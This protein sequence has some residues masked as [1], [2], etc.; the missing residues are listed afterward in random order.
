MHSATIATYNRIAPQYTKSHFEPEFWLKEFKIFRRL[1]RGKKVIDVGC[2]A[3]RDA[4]LFVKNKFNYTGVDA[5][6]GMLKIAKNRVR[7]GRF[8]LM[9]FY[10]LDSLRGKSFDGFWAAASLLHVPKKDIGKILKK[11]KTLMKKNAVGFISIKE[12]D[13]TGINEGVLKEQKYGGVKRYFSFYTNKEF[14]KILEESGYRIIRVIAKRGK[15]REGTKWL[16]YF[17]KGR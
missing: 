7:K 8:L 13:E 10:K 16:S 17:V 15:D 14:K 6:R 1:I 9:D 11:I 2:G 3:G 4:V 12:R 5:A